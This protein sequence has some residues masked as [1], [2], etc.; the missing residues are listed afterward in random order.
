MNISELITATRHG[1]SYQQ[2]AEVEVEGNPNR[3]RWH[4]LESRSKQVRAFPE[5]MTIIAMAHVLG[6][7]PETI[8]RAFAESLGVPFSEE[9][10][11]L[12]NL[13]PPDIDRLSDEAV[14]ALLMSVRAH[15]APSNVVPLS[16]VSD[17]P[18]STGARGMGKVADV[19]K[20]EP[21]GD[22]TPE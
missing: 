2:L 18:A 14:Q 17:R 19:R 16:A 6:V 8:V 1:R 15:L 20:Q 12:V 22:T 11:R 3:A 10:S 13:L 4:Q 21:D 7:T 9:R 5:P